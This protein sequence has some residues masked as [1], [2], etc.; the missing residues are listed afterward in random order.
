VPPFYSVP[1]I[2]TDSE[3]SGRIA[4]L[5]EGRLVAYGEN[6]QIITARST[7]VAIQVRVPDLR[8]I[9]YVLDVQFEMTDL[10]CSTNCLIGPEVNKKIVG[11]VVGMSLYVVTAG[12][13]LKTKVIA[14]GPP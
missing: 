3:K 4:V 8:I 9:E 2:V 5:Q 1:G 12:T 6:Q 14:I 7:C 13:T 10:N 11:N